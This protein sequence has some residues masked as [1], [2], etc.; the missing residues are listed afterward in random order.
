MSQILASGKTGAD[1]YDNRAIAP[2][3]VL[4]RL[5]MRQIATSFKKLYEVCK[6][7]SY[8]GVEG[9]SEALSNDLSI[10]TP[11]NILDYDEDL[12]QGIQ[13]LIANGCRLDVDAA[14][15][16]N[17]IILKAPKITSSNAPDGGNYTVETPLPFE[18]KDGLRFTFRATLTNTGATQ[19]IITGLVGMPAAVD[20]LDET[21]T[22]LVGGEIISGRFYEVVC[23]TISTVKKLILVSANRVVAATE[24]VAGIAEIATATEAKAFTDDQ[25]IITPLKLSNAISQISIFEDQK[26]SGTVGGTFT[27]GSWQTRT[28][29]T[30]F[31]GIAGVSLTSNQITLPAGSYNIIAKATANGVELHKLKLR[32]ITDSNDSLNGLNN[33]TTL[34]DDVSTVATCSG[35]I[36]ITSSKVFEVQHY[37]SSTRASIGFGNP[38][39]FGV[40]EVYCQIFIQKI[41]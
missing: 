41:A 6:G 20:I 32:N 25:R 17:N 3:K 28:L 33:N 12:T 30:S 4:P 16:I 2:T 19:G 40:N 1:K 29:N 7:Y 14:S 11:S 27:A 23:V 38:C 22:A 10:I 34:S 37:C 13:T 5:D 15:T 31:N 9:A 8:S 26:A 24:S 35:V 21:N 39:S 36:V 18:F